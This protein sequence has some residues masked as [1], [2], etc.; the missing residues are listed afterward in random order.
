VSAAE[1]AKPVRPRKLS[2]K[3]QRELEAL[4]ER[5]ES[6][7]AERSQLHAAVNDVEF[8]KQPGE[9]IA[10]TMARLEALTTEI[11]D[12]YTRWQALEA[13]AAGDD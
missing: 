7:E 3:E 12:S 1:E 13:A 10:A 2:Y 9:K 8:Y 5:I 11:E 4:P 6:L